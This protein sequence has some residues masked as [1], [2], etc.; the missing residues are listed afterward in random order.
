MMNSVILNNGQFPL[1]IDF[2]YSKMYKK[3]FKL[4]DKITIARQQYEVRI[5]HNPY[6][7]FRKLPDKKS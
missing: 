5:Y 1:E 7:T 6:F 3:F 4:M 2:N